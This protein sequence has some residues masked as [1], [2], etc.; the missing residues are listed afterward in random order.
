M[1]RTGVGTEMTEGNKE[2]HNDRNKMIARLR[3]VERR[4]GKEQFGEGSTRNYG[5]FERKTHRQKE[6]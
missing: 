5:N 4:K 2:K 6:I 3:E 1:R